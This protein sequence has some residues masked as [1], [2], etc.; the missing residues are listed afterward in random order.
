MQV[1]GELTDLL[2]VLRTRAAVAAFCSTVQA[3]VGGG[4]SVAVGPVGRSADASLR[5]G[6]SGG[7]VCYSYSLSRGAFVGACRACIS[8]N[9]RSGHGVV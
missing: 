7:A 8:E 5:M 6:R 9:R 2:I 1:G 4:A 3:G